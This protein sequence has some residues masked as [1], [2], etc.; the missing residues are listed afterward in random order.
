[1]ESYKYAQIHFT[2]WGNLGALVGAQDGLARSCSSLM[3]HLDPSDALVHV[4]ARASRCV[5][6]RVNVFVC[7]RV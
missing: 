6:A 4:A 3:E 1:M 5:S 7:V 2:K